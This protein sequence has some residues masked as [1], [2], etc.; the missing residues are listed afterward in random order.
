M[1]WSDFKTIDRFYKIEPLNKYFHEVLKGIDT[2][3]FGIKKDDTKVFNEVYYQMTRMAYERAL[4][5]DFLT[6]IDEIKEDMGRSFGVELVMSML[7]F[8]MSLVDKE[9][10]LFNSF[11]LLTIKERFEDCPY[12]KP[13]SIC[14]NRLIKGKRRIKYD[15][16]PH[17]VSAT[18]LADKYVNWQKITKDYDPGVMI[19]LLSLWEKEDD[20]RAL[21][22]MIKASVNFRTP[23]LQKT[24]YDQVSSI[25]RTSLFSKGNKTK[26]S[27]DVEIRLKELDSKVNI[28]QREN[29]V[30]QNKIAELQNEN[31]VDHEWCSTKAQINGTMAHATAI[32]GFMIAGLVM[33]DIYQKAT[34]LQ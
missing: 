23:K 2:S 17:P 34:S 1:L 27:S 5:A 7:Y 9:S 31:L 8:T 30:F 32:F 20:R 10:R 19:E 6:Y 4:P 33:Q 25:L 16:K 24:Y 3:T 26:E 13:F 11:L 14:Y 15:F 21:A 29:A 12:W 28:L 18:E 22:G